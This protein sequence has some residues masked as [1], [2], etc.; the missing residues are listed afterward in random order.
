M[1][2]AGLK[3]T[4]AR[5]S[6]FLLA[7][8]LLVSFVSAVGFADPDDVVL[9]SGYED[10]AVIA[11]PDQAVAGV[12]QAAAELADYVERSTGA[13]LPI[14]TM[15]ELASAGL[16]SETAIV[17]VGTT[18]AGG[19]PDVEDALDGLDRDG[20]VIHPDGHT[21]TI[22][23]PSV[24]GTKNG[25]S[26]FLER[27]LGVRWLY[28][29]ADGEDVPQQADLEVPPADVVEE[30]AFTFRMLSPLGFD[31]YASGLSELAKQQML[32]TQRNRLQGSYNG[33]IRFHHNLYNLFSPSVFGST[34]PE[35]YPNGTPPASNSVSGW[36]PC[37]S[38]PDTVTA[39]IDAINDYFSIRPHEKSYSLGVNDGGGYC[40]QNPSH[41]DY[42]GT[43]N[44]LGFLD[45]SDIYYDWVNQVAEGVLQTY[46]DKWFGVMAYTNVAEPP[47][48]A[49][50][51]RIVPL[52]SRD[53]MTWAD[54]DARE[55]GEQQ[56]EDWKLNAAQIG[57]YDYVYGVSYALPRIYPHLM[58]DN[59]A[60][61]A[62]E[63]VVGQYAELYGNL[64]DG[65]KAYVSAKLQWNPEA[66]VDDLLDEWYERM[67]GPVAADDLAAYYAIW[68]NFWTE[69]V[70]DSAW[71]QNNK[72]A[73]Y[74]PFTDAS[75]MALVTDEELADSRALLESVKLNA[76]TPGQEARADKLLQ[77]FEYYEASGMSYPR[78]M[79]T[80]LDANAAIALLDRFQDSIDLAERRKQIIPEL[81]GDPALMFP[82]QPPFA[83]WD[84]WN[85]SIFW[86]LSDYIRANEPS[87]GTVTTVVYNA[88]VSPT[89]SKTRD[90]AQAILHSL[91][92]PNLTSNPSFESG[93]TVPTSWSL[94]VQDVGSITRSTNE[95]YSGGASAL[96]SGITRGGP[97]QT[98]AIHSGVAAA[99]VRFYSPSNTTSTGTITW[100]LNLKTAAGQNLKTIVGD[101]VKLNA[102]P[103][104]WSTAELLKE[105]PETVN[106]QQV[107]QGQF[108]ITLDKVGAGN[109]VYL[110]D[111][112]VFQ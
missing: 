64:G 54:E 36:Q 68:E 65:P 91:S 41:P 101:P 21:V 72:T 112:A 76:T 46:P 30:P 90:F 13:E 39:A 74:L 61:D 60:Y 17:Y 44:S 24:W 31:P 103:G 88:S 55:V 8:P 51:D 22:I 27:Y 110:D 89:P 81:A 84:G 98:F 52:I 111:A 10:Q 32:W 42:P 97:N 33:A 96:V 43:T 59:Y 106:G 99:R 4:I 14:L 48:F 85:P 6:F 28:P 18:A 102:T 49:L 40:E 83:A 19:D 5:L 1:G 66:D 93:T 35:F 104:A 50:N 38:N 100:T 67:V 15:T 20:F 78:P 69:R 109:I 56:V 11:I 47:S 45:M 92:G 57:F 77:M 75:Y 58:A 37:F 53:R 86:T 2:K 80:P 9:V 105:I 23:G 62:D 82:S 29:G 12:V 26:E 94:W 79:E 108:I 3:R 95:A 87:G 16:G 107:T 71:F 25:V 70:P 73:T 34:H 63:P 7:V